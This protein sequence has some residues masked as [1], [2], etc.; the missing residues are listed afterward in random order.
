MSFRHTFLAIN[1]LILVSC[2]STPPVVYHEKYGETTADSEIFKTD[3][4]ECYKE[5][6]AK[7]IDAEQTGVTAVDASLIA[8]QLYLLFSNTNSCISNKGWVLFEQ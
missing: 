6:E 7:N 3:T 2:S 8:T 4:I 1:L 5:A